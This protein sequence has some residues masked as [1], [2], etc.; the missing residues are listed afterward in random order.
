MIKKD[1]EIILTDEDV[2]EKY[3]DNVDNYFREM[4]VEEQKDLAIMVA[5]NL[6]ELMEKPSD[7]KN[8]GYIFAYR[9]IFD[10]I[11]SGGPDS[12]IGD[13]NYRAMQK[14]I[15]YGSSGGNC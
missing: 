1:E 9:L 2:E 12:V 3:M 7:P 8:E 4:S 13:G 14:A 15:I 10:Y 6:D 5:K 11:C